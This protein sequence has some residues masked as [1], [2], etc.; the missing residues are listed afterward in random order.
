MFSS[1][2]K[3]VYSYPFLY[4]VCHVNIQSKISLIAKKYIQFIP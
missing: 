4:V 1:K 3:T 2:A